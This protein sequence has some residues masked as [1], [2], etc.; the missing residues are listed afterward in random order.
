MVTSNGT[1]ETEEK[2]ESKRRLGKSPDLADSLTLIYI[3]E[4]E[5]QEAFVVDWIDMGRFD[6]S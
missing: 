5:Q 1:I 2:E 6:R 4:E 3:T